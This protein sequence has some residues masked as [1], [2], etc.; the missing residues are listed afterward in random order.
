MPS[1]FARVVCVAA[2]GRYSRALSTGRGKVGDA[3]ESGQ[4]AGT[5]D[6]HASAVSASGA[7]SSRRREGQDYSPSSLARM[8]ALSRVV[9]PSLV[10][11]ADT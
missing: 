3:R 11:M 10:M 4:C 9:A 8:T 5:P 7:S 6:G 2:R 1:T